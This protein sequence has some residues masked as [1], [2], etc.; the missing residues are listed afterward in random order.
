MK[1]P[2]SSSTLLAEIFSRCQ[3][4]YSEK[5]LSGYRSDLQSFIAWCDE[6]DQDWA[7]AA[8]A[9][10]ARFIDYQIRTLSIATVKRRVEAIK[11]AHRMLDLT[12]PASSSDV[13]LAIRRAA[14]ARPSRPKQSMGLTT[15]LLWPILAA[16][17]DSLAGKRDAALISVGYDTL[18][19]SNE[20][21][22]MR[23]E[24]LAPDL[25]TIL[26]PR[27]K[28][29]PF[30]E[31]RIAYLSPSTK[32]RLAQWLEISG[33]EEGPLFQGLHTQ[34]LS[35][36]HLNTAS[37]RRIVKRAAALAE[38]GGKAA[39][40]SG[41]SMRI[42]AAQDMMV[43]GIDQVA[44]M[45]AGGW[46]TINV[47]GRYVENARTRVIHERRWE[48]LGSSASRHVDELTINQV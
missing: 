40:L 20:L 41:H 1:R 36:R 47:L 26:I 13:R 35:G 14:R 32:H 21:A 46:K 18:C 27:T 34:K 15:D 6:C 7:P 33:F 48:A 10:V 9:T 37:I 25:A 42:G 45:Q 38:I 11:F 29:D 31:G 39:G 22:A 43:A 28:S 12:S 17:P 16:C 8:S 3:G 44:I 30:G 2:S 4:A 24:H 19:R 23:A 5:T